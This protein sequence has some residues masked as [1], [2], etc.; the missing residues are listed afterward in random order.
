MRIE[1]KIDK[2][3]NEKNDSRWEKIEKEV[4]KKIRE[5]DFKFVRKNRVSITADHDQKDDV[6][7]IVKKYNL[8]VVDT[9]DKKDKNLFAVDVELK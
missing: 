6:L 7:D 3:L 1:E 8:N 9:E 5:P 2:Y 4:R